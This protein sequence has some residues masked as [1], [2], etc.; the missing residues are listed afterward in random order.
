MLIINTP[1]NPTGKILSNQ[2]LAQIAD[3]VKSFPRVIVISD[4]VYEHMIYDKYKKLPRFAT[5]SGM[6][7][8]TVTIHSAGKF[9]SATGLRVGWAIGPKN[10]INY[11]HAVSQ[12]NTFCMN[13]PIQLSVRDSL[14]IANNPYKGHSNYYEWLRQHYQNSR[15]YFIQELYKVPAFKG[16]YWIPEGAYFVMLDISN[17]VIPKHNYVLDGD[18]QSKYGKDYKYLLNLAYTKKL[19][20]IP[21]S[22]FYTEKNKHLGEKFVRLAFCKK[23]ETMDAGFKNLATL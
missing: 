17:D 8:R 1:N 18:N 5:L 11:I 2:E 7:D 15:D 3:I 19:V 21:V 12:Y 22:V 13:G 23:K 16:K 20:S 10:L 14:E 4:E 6:W 9:L